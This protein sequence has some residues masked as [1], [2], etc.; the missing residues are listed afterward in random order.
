MKFV[1][2]DT[3]V[4][5]G[6]YVIHDEIHQRAVQQLTSLAQ[7]GTRF[8]TTDTVHTEFCNG[9]AKV[10]L[11]Q[12]AAAVVQGLMARTDVTLIRV[13]E[14]LWLRAFGLYQARSDK[15]WGLTDC[16]LLFVTASASDS[17]QGVKC[18]Q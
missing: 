15:E 18:K 4:L 6:L 1:F 10:A 12:R 3:L 2:L 17:G 16:I 13:T 9:L 5:I 8:V 11:R 7:D 14:P